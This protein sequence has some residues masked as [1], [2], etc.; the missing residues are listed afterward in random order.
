M[1]EGMYIFPPLLPVGEGGRGMMSKR[2]LKTVVHSYKRAFKNN[3]LLKEKG[4]N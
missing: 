1:R 3:N 2:S 4:Q